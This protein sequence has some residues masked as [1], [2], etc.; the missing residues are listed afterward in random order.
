MEGDSHYL[1]LN[2]DKGVSGAR[3]KDKL[4]S[5]PQV[6]GG[7]GDSVQKRGVSGEEEY[8]NNKVMS[9]RFYTYLS[10]QV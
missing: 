8:D 10:S 4:T 2:Y 5:S 1:A 7:A 3:N 9:F 6:G